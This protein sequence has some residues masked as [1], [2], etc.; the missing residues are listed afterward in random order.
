VKAFVQ[1]AH[2]GEFPNENFY[3]AWRAFSWYGFDVIKFKLEEAETLEVSYDTPVYASVPVTGRLLRKMGV[4]TP[5]LPNYPESLKSFL[6]RKIEIV[7]IEDIIKDLKEGKKWFIKPLDEERKRFDGFV[8]EKE[9]DLVRA[10]YYPEMR[11]YRSEVIDFKA[12]WRVFI[13][14]DQILSVRPYKGSFRFHPDVTV[15][16]EAVR[17]L[18]NPPIA[19]CLDF[20][21]FQ[22][23]WTPD[24]YPD[25]KHVLVEATDAFSFGHYG[26]D[27]TFFGQMIIGRWEEIWKCNSK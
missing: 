10:A 7:P 17:K 27:M 19:Y 1:I 2:D 8:V 16:E 3:S 5:M 23:G 24:D 20:G 18:K 15:I 14:D 22:K 11:V 12:E 21:T 6:G 25:Y 26:L 13:F 4:M 9:I